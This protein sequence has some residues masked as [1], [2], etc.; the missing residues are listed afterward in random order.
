MISAVAARQSDDICASVIQPAIA[1]ARLDVAV[2]APVFG[3]ELSD[4]G[5]W[6]MRSIESTQPRFSGSQPTSAERS[7]RAAI[8]SMSNDPA[9][10]GVI[11]YDRYSS[12]LFTI[13]AGGVVNETDLSDHPVGSAPNWLNNYVDLYTQSMQT[14]LINQSGS[15]AELVEYMQWSM[16]RR[17]T[18]L[19]T[20]ASPMNPTVA[21]AF[22][23]NWGYQ[24]FPWFW[25]L[26][27]PVAITEYL[28][29]GAPTTSSV[30]VQDS[31]STSEDLISL[32]PSVTEAEPGES[33]RIDI[34]YPRMQGVTDVS[35][36]AYA[37]RSSIENLPM[38]DTDHT[39]E[40]ACSPG[41]AAEAVKPAE[42]ARPVELDGSSPPQYLDVFVLEDV[43]PGLTLT[44]CFELVAFGGGQEL[45]RSNVTAT[46]LV[47]APD[48][49]LSD[50]ARENTFAAG[51][52]SCSAP[53]CI[54]LEQV[55][56]NYRSVDGSV[57]GSCVTERVDTPNGP[58]AWCDYE[59]QPG[60]AT[61]LS[62]D[63][64][65][66]P[67]GWVITSENPVRYTVPENPDGPLGP[68]FF[69][70]AQV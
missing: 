11:W 2:A 12:T 15:G 33:V 63:E 29:S 61:M 17:D 22:L 55:T 7:L 1:Q 14:F 45:F 41:N 69:Q 42:R 58:S 60:M 27:D 21:S 67:R 24:Q 68:V 53:N 48:T 16:A 34:V 50:D 30:A 5:T 37:E 57:S 20:V 52:L 10:R 9:F 66:L 8:D 39:G 3:C 62:V 18:I 65:T 49:R 23:S 40:Y 64:S 31:G 6:M 44:V 46:I 43:Q 32:R 56:I 35:F 28:A 36:L 59:Y 47:V 51:V 26:A 19:S 54:A 70:A 4:T 38:V 25:Q 13:G